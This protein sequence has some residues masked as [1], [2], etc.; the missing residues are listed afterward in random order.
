M[1][2][3]IA[4]NDLLSHK[5]DWLHTDIEGYDAELLQAIDPNF[6]PP[7]IIF[8][9]NNLK[10]EDKLELE[11]YLIDLGYFLNR[12]DPVSYLAVKK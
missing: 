8:E 9:H 4:I 5:I 10:I 12:Q 1:R 7:F 11:N 2:S 3:S 6:L